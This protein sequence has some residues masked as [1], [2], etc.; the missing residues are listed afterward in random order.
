[1]R[2][3]SY[4]LSVSLKKSLCSEDDVVLR[5]SESLDDK[6]L[7]TLM[8]LGL[9]TRFP[10]VYEAWE[11][12]GVE[13]QEHFRRALTERKDEIH[14]SLEKNSGEIQAAVREVVIGEILKAFP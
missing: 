9:S 14:A 10:G 3:E 7:K 6:A 2:S 8:R 1:V 5:L 12:Q 13:I 11:S 4:S